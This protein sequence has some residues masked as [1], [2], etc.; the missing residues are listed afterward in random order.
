MADAAGPAAPTFPPL[1]IV[2]RR[3]L[4]S[5]AGPVVLML[6]AAHLVLAQVMAAIPLVSTIHA[7]STVVVVTWC[8]LFSKRAEVLVACAAYVVGCEVLW[9]QTGASTPWEISM[10][11]LVA[12]FFVGLVRFAPRP[13]RRFRA[14]IPIV[15]LALLTPGILATIGALGV[16]GAQQYVGFYLGGP[17]ALGLGV[18]FLRQFWCRWE[19]LRPVLWA[20]VYPIIATLAL[21]TLSTI[22]L[23][24]ADFISAESNVA[25][26]GGFGPN[27]VSAVIGLAALACAFLALRER[28]WLLRATAAGLMMWCLVQGALTF[29]RGGL[30]NVLVAAAV[31]LPHFLTRLRHAAGLFL[32][33]IVVVLLC[34]LVFLPRLQELT[35]GT[36]ETR[37]TEGDGS[38]VELAE[39]DLRIFTE[40]ALTGTGVGLSE[41]ERGGG[42]GL[43]AAHTEYSRLLAEHGL[44]GAAALACM[45]WMAATSYRRASGVMARAWAA[46]LIAWSAAEMSHAAMRLSATPFV[47]ALAALVLVDA[48]R[49]PPE[50]AEADEGDEDVR[51]IEPAAADP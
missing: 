29:S 14:A 1:Q 10:Y 12:T 39:T 25:A 21:A 34:G 38:R 7:I 44:L 49:P 11:L 37:L 46:A 26:S 2:R 42:A 50:G 17:V 4:P 6:L 48:D 8:A 19:V 47:F 32:A 36:L 13:P 20:L 30:L 35:G 41:E 16:F 5:G 23:S 33:A 24:A 22:G 28:S 9:R 43:Y 27:Q 18:L 45:V 31:A 3:G 15:Y 40:H 51:P